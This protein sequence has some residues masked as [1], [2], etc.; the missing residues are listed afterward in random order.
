MSVGKAD[1]VLILR[2]RQVARH[3]TCWKLISATARKRTLLG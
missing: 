2:A 1:A 3:L